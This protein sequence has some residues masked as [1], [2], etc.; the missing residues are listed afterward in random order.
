MKNK[1]IFIMKL[2]LPLLLIVSFIGARFVLAAEAPIV[3]KTD[4]TEDIEN[5]LLVDLYKVSDIGWNDT[6]ANYYF[7]PTSSDLASVF[8]AN[9]SLFSKSTEG[10]YFV[11]DTSD[12]KKYDFV[13]EELMVGSF[14]DSIIDIVKEQPS[15]FKEYEFAKS[16]STYSTNVTFDDAN[17]KGLYLLFV[18][19]DT[20]QIS[21]AFENKQI[22]N[23]EGSHYASLANSADYVYS[24]RPYLL[25]YNGSAN[26]ERAFEINVKYEK[27]NRFGKLK[28]EKEVDELI[29]RNET[30]V[31]KVEANKTENFTDPEYG[32]SLSFNIKD[33]VLDDPK[34]LDDIRM[35][36]Y[37]RVTEVY[38]GSSY[39]IDSEDHRIVNT[40][41]VPEDENGVFA[42]VR[43]KNIVD[44][45]NKKG[46]GVNNSYVSS[47]T[48]NNNGETEISWN[49]SNDLGGTNE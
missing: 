19:G 45:L 23:D 9:T 36:Y 28:I 30:F 47:E 1:K 4:I 44:D 37:V 21:N 29:N 6:D 27:E 15:G 11:E 12:P 31:F 39:K 40:Q 33:N 17:D 14:A 3:I 16:G 13:N 41:I 46:Y 20:Y 43:F 7:V 26:L 48:T 10:Y 24:F 34:V 2:F 35:Y 42:S 32:K 49:W 8:D 38:D 5:K 25:F 18:R 22:L